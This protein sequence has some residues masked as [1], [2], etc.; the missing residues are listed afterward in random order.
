[1]S[2]ILRDPWDFI[3]T[4]IKIKLKV[5]SLRVINFKFPLQPHKKYHIT[6]YEE[7]GFSSLT[8]MKYDYTTNSH[9]YT[10]WK[11]WGNVLF[12]LGSETV[13]WH[14]FVE[15]LASGAISNACIT[16]TLFLL[17]WT[18]A[19]PRWLHSRPCNWSFF[20][21]AVSMRQISSFLELTHYWMV[22]EKTTRNKWTWTWK[23]RLSGI[24]FNNSLFSTKPVQ[25]NWKE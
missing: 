3:Q 9:I 14:V 16:P 18:R 25:F 19:E 21:R 2:S 8:Q 12:E 15:V 1:M 23:T 4:H 20:F 17:Y 22:A 13:N 5:T 7:L 24:N 10:S 11:G 6:Q